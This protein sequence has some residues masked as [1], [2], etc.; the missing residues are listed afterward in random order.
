M[1]HDVIGMEQY[2]AEG[3]KPLDRCLADVRLADLYVLILA[4]RYGHVPADIQSN[5][6]SLSVT[7]LEFRAAQQAGKP[8]LAFLL[9]PDAPWPPSEVDA[10]STNAL[11]AANVA[12]LRNDVGASYLAG[13][14]SSPDDLASQ[15][16]A[17]VAAQGL[18]QQLVERLLGQTSVGAEDMGR[19]GGGN[20]LN[21]STILGIK[22]MVRTAGQVRAIVI[23]LGNGDQ[24]WSTR[25]H[26]LASLLR[27]LTGVR[28][29]VFRDGSR[30]FAGM[31]SPGAV[32]DGLAAA[33]RELDEFRRS[34]GDQASQDTDREIDRQLGLWSQILAQ[35]GGNEQT[36]KVGV[37][38]ELLKGWLGERLI[39]R[40]IKVERTGPTMAQ[41]QQIVDSLLP[42][43]PIERS[44]PDGE[45]QKLTLQVVDRD[46]FALELAREWVRTGLPRTPLRWTGL[47]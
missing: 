25:L 45:T 10:L 9:D 15:A 28:Q 35:H 16:A 2:V 1:G 11:A 4:W 29:L 22:E 6:T 21:D 32:I 34:L 17:S 14:F 39:S 13:I 8:I 20:P 26:L 3:S 18:G 40:C 31:A 42:D 36:L 37:R 7:E 46:E 27:L 12:R 30:R 24:W 44:E 19:F 33:F 23:D 38:A 41:V 43:V 47:G 5:P